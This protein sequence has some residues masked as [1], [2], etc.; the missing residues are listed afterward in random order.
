MLLCGLPYDRGLNTMG[1]F[2]NLDDMIGVLKRRLALIA[3][4]TMIGAAI[5][6]FYASS[7]PRVYEATALIQIELPYISDTTTSTSYGPRAKNR[8][9]LIK[10][11]LM[12]R[13]A[14]EG[15]VSELGLFDDTHMSDFEKMD[16]LRQS[17][18]I[19]QIIDPADTWRPDAV[20]S[21]LLITVRLGDP[22][23]AA[24]VANTFLERILMQSQERQ[25]QQASEAL[26]FFESEAARIEN[27]INALEA[28]IAD[29]KRTNV[30]KMPEG[31]ASLRT[32]LAGLKQTE[33]EIDRQI[34]GLKA[35]ANRVREDVL[36][37]QVKELEEQLALVEQRIAD[38]ETALAEAPQVEREFSRLMREL[39]QLQEQLSVITRRRA[40]AEMGQMLTS[41]QQ[42]ERFE[43][44]EAA[45][46]PQYPVAPSR[47]KVTVAG[48]A[49]AL[50]IGA[51]LAIL[52][53]ML[54]PAI[55][56]SGQLERELGVVPIVT[57]PNLD[58]K[59]RARPGKWAWILALGTGIA[60][61]AW[62]F[63]RRMVEVVANSVK[64]V[65]LTGRKRL[66]RGQ[67]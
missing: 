1:Q 43:I 35:N 14:L 34:I 33:L 8:L 37:R 9:N 13:G 16:A 50:L 5:S 64:S 51:G 6:L 56:T 48:T 17:V 2:S 10:Q 3:G 52:L 19:D 66:V 30:D 20:P 27:K 61:A 59:N 60:I 57:I 44:L 49:L 42:T 67:A 36:N 41:N 23:A 62:P 4:V 21:G 7:L 53:E 11:Q 29:F 24:L 45:L 39:D 63:I 46:V 28:E 15:V 58:S 32:Q 38:A 26:S 54:N 22:E 18:S 12:A 40:E 65:I 55:R 25:Q 31:V 47:K